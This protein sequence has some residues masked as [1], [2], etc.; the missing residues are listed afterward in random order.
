MGLPADY[1]L[2]NKNISKLE[3]KTIQIIQNEAQREQNRV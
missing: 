2:P 3:E 1:T